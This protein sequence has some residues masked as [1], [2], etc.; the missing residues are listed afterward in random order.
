MAILKGGSQL[1]R[2][3]SAPPAPPLNE[4]LVYRYCTL[5]VIF[6][7]VPQC[8]HWGVFP[9]YQH[10]TGVLHYAAKVYFHTS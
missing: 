6:L 4:A 5:S 10:Y 2:G 7:R 1:P 8:R 9:H 3:A